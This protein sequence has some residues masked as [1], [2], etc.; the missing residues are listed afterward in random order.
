MSVIRPSSS[1]GGLGDAL[2]DAVAEVPWQVQD[3]VWRH[4]HRHRVAVA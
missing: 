3:E 4:P 2:V 1:G